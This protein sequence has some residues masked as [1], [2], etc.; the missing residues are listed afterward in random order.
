M[1]IHL[2]SLCAVSLLASLTACGQPAVTPQ[3]TGLPF[4]GPV[5]QG[6]LDNTA[7]SEVSGL[8]ASRKNPG[9]LWVHNDSGGEA[10]VYLISHEGKTLATYTLANVKSRD[11]ED[12]AVMPGPD[13][14]QTYLYVGDI[15]DNEAQYAT[16]RI[17][18]FAEP[19]LSE[20]ALND[21]LPLVDTIRTVETLEFAYPDGARDAET[22]L[23]DPLDQAVYVISK[24][25][26]FVNIYQTA[27]SGQTAVDTVEKVG[28]LPHEQV[29]ILEQLVGG[30]ISPDGQEIL[31]KSYVQMFYWQR[32]DDTTSLVALL[33]TEPTVLPY[34]P[35]PQ[36]EAVGFATDGSGYYT[37]SE[38]QSGIKPRLYFYPRQEH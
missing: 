31:L 12:M 24:R 35:E 26:S 34:Q 5:D 6:E 14:D 18:R 33:Q 27:F 25:E 37:L 4:A 15:G 38:K 23:V 28:Q 17:Y 13:P 21:T 7:L 22:L 1:N 19:Q 8:V 10:A 16:K 2:A 32:P 3:K 20:T 11:W 9:A 36:G 29:G 30:D